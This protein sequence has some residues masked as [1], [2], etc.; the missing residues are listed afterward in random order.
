MSDTL[1]C[2]Y[3]S[4]KLNIFS[5]LRKPG[6][7]PGKSLSLA[8]NYV[9]CFGETSIYIMSNRMRNLHK[10]YIFFVLVGI[11]ICVVPACS[12]W[13]TWSMRWHHSQIMTSPP[14]KKPYKYS[15]CQ[16]S[17]VKDFWQFSWAGQ[18]LWRIPQVRA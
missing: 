8:Q 12:K 17:K 14:T 9:F 11:C 5:D 15:P 6:L 4:M 1:F 16:D 13:E 2:V 18:R 10:Q 7:V 3:K